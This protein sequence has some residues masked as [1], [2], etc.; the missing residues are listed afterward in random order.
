MTKPISCYFA[1]L[2]VMLV[3]CEQDQ[4][5]NTINKTIKVNN[6]SKHLVDTITH[7]TQ[8]TLDTDSAYKQLVIIV[9]KD[10]WTNLKTIDKEIGENSSSKFHQILKKNDKKIYDLYLELS[11]IK[12]NAVLVARA[13]G[14]EI[15]SDGRERIT[16]HY[17]PSLQK[18]L[19][20]GTEAFQN[21]YNLDNRL[22]QFLQ[23]N[24]CFC[25][26]GKEETYCNDEGKCKLIN[27]DYWEQ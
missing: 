24:Y 20:K 4:G 25:Y 18:E 2:C 3:S 16:E 26:K 15:R 23:N 5:G 12:K 17:I 9:E 13:R 6:T 21:K 14:I 11:E 27:G 7:S 19:L 22:L 1:F 8:N 10:F